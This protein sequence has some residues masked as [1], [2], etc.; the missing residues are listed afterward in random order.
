MEQSLDLA[1]RADLDNEEDLDVNETVA[2]AIRFVN[3]QATKQR[4]DLEATLNDNIS[5]VRGDRGK[6]RQVLLNLLLNAIQATPSGGTVRIAT[7]PADGEVQIEVEDTG[8]GIEPENLEKLFRPFFTTKPTGTGLGLAISDRIV[9][10][11]AGKIEATSTSPD[12]ARFKITLP[13][14]P[15]DRPSPRG[16]RRGTPI[17]FLEGRKRRTAMKSRNI[18]VGT[19][20][21]ASA[22]QAYPFA[23][24]I[25]QRLRATIILVHVDELMEFGF[26]TAA[27]LNDNLERLAQARQS[28]LEEAEDI[29]RSAKLDVTIETREG[30]P[31]EQ[32]LLAADD[33]DADMVI[34]AKQGVRGIER[35]LL[36]STTRRLV[37][38]ARRPTMVIPVE[39]A[40]K[41]LTSIASFRRLL[42]PTDFSDMAQQGLEY[43]A[44]LAGQLSAELNIVHVLKLPTVISPI[45]GESMMLVP[46]E[47][48]GRMEED[49]NERLEK[50]VAGLNYSKAEIQILISFSVAEALADEAEKS[51]DLIVVPSHGKGA[52]K[53][54]VLGS[55]TEE[56]V[57]RS[58]KPVLVLPPDILKR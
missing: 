23:A 52:I 21:S 8:P 24:G 33:H 58:T 29:F 11:M 46:E 39:T 50:V 55:T 36:G 20:L 44:D 42:A 16:A 37:R 6:L 13:S 38:G 56:L 47:L 9:R 28:C 40:N 45:P 19:D 14:L 27:E 34:V 7:R 5:A 15:D 49:A 54:T 32:I 25:A 35:L 18:I 17:A 48:R 22:K 51:A 30:T 41:P 57:K 3:H 12:G 43:T 31:S 10:G 1:R 2:E 26:H 53:A 4:I